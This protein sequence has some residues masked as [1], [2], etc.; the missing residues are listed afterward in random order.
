MLE[1]TIIEDA[2]TSTDIKLTSVMAV[3][4][5]LFFAR[6]AE[7]VPSASA[8]SPTRFLS[9]FSSASKAETSSS[10]QCLEQQGFPTDPKRNSV[11]ARETT[12]KQTGFRTDHVFVLIR[13]FR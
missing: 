3:T 12:S 4:P 6:N 13:H 10:H 7:I 11:N 1:W 5:S 2:L 9:A 8:E